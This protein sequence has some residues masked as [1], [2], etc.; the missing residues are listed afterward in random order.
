MIYKIPE[1][2][3]EFKE[4]IEKITKEIKKK[5]KNYSKNIETSQRMK[6]IAPKLKLEIQTRIDELKKLFLRC[7]PIDL[8]SYLSYTYSIGDS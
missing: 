8:M 6:E 5:G 4:Q 1:Q 7:E 3:D 2:P